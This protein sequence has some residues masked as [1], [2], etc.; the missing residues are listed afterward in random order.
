MDKR[1]FVIRGFDDNGTTVTEEFWMPMRGIVSEGDYVRSVRLH[2]IEA[3]WE[4]RWTPGSVSWRVFLVHKD[5]T[6]EFV[7]HGE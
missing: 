6:E 1:G 2:A 3:L 4:A 5:D 7:L